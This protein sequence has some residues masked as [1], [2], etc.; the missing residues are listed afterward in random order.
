[1]LLGAVS[2]AQ[3]LPVSPRRY[4]EIAASDASAHVLWSQ[5]LGVLEAG[6]TRA[7]FTALALMDPMHPGQQL[8]GV[9]VDLSTAEWKGVA[10]IQE[11]D[12]PVMKKAA[13]WLA[14]CAKE[15]PKETAPFLAQGPSSD[16]AP[17]LFL[18]YQRVE[19]R[20]TS[21]LRYRASPGW[22]SLQLTGVPPSDVAAIF[23]RAAKA[24]RAH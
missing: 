24:L 2:F 15:Y 8:R 6:E 7:A 9:R 10:Y 5:P 12:V 19:N 18:S 3:A 17:S 4:L 16:P 23:A 11:S 21:Y 14:K 20:P 13:D 1:M 22:R